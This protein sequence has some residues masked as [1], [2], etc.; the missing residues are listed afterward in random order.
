MTMVKVSSTED[1]FMFDKG[2]NIIPKFEN[3]FVPLDEPI[4]S[5]QI[6]PKLSIYY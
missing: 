4:K 2:N 6:N 1:G 3:A 5:L